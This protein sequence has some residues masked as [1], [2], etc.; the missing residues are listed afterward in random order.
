MISWDNI[1]IDNHYIIIPGA[2]GEEID[3][4][5]FDEA[6]QFMTNALRHIETPLPKLEV[7]YKKGIEPIIENEQVLLDVFHIIQKNVIVHSVDV[8][9]KDVSI[10][11]NCARIHLETGETLRITNKELRKY[12]DDVLKRVTID[13]PKLQVQYREGGNPI[14]KNPEIIDEII[15]LIQKN[16]IVR[17]EEVDWKNIKVTDKAFLISIPSYKQIKL[18]HNNARAFMND[19]VKRVS[20]KLPKIIVRFEEGS[21]PI[22]INENILESVI[23]TIK[24][25]ILVDDV[26]IDW[27]DVL[28]L[29]HEIQIKTSFC[30]LLKFRNYYAK[31]FMNKMLHRISECLPKLV[32]RFKEGEKPEIVNESILSDIITILQL[33]HSY[34]ELI[35]ANKNISDALKALSIFSKKDTRI[36]LPRDMSAYIH[37]LS[38]KHVIETYPIVP[39]TEYIGGTYEEGALFTIIRGGQPHI[40]WENFKDSRSTYV[41]A[42]SEANY[43]ERRQVIFN[44]I[45]T[46]EDGKRMFLHSDECKAIFGEKPEMIVHNNMKSWVS[47]LMNVENGERLKQ[48]LKQYEN[49][50]LTSIFHD[51]DSAKIII[52]YLGDPERYFDPDGTNG[53]GIAE[54]NDIDVSRHYIDEYFDGDRVIIVEK[55]LTVSKTGRFIDE[56]TSFTTTS[57][58]EYRDR[59]NY[60]RRTTRREQ[61]SMPQDMHERYEQICQKAV[62]T[63][64]RQDSTYSYNQDEDIHVDILKDGIIV[65]STDTCPSSEW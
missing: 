58:E 53:Y 21:L 64:F 20:P 14:V 55:T 11:D 42:C 50:S 6:R 16:I 8:D 43:L 1:S 4:I 27:N 30:E 56:G 10:K 13:S 32:V 44:Y 7:T 19:I 51:L 62:D 17:N 63:L 31:T 59:E 65:Y 22:V 52:R 37:F 36:F 41:F 26:E 35:R 3:V 24:D 61:A 28:F 2:F 23:S 5:R 39:V 49:H 47:R 60:F 34:S 12:M 18:Q 48:E 25:H 40:V 33:T 15:A 45:L 54:T 9:W 57:N 38:D 46:E 29:D